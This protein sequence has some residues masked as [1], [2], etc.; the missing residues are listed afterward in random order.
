MSI[1]S[2]LDAQSAPITVRQFFAHGDP[3]PLSATLAHVP[4]LMKTALPF[5]GTAFGASGIDV[6]TKEIVILRT[7][8]FLI[9]VLSLR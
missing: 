6:R 8:P 3:G 9:N 2:Q 4:D 1:V 7:L 5:L